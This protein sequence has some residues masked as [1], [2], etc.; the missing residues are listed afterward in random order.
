MLQVNVF[1]SMLTRLSKRK[2]TMLCIVIG[3][4]ISLGMYRC[5]L[6]YIP[7]DVTNNDVFLQGLPKILDGL[8]IVQLSDIHLGPY[9][10]E[11]LVNRAVDIANRCNPDIAVLTGD[12]TS[13]SSDYVDKCMEIMAKLKPKHGIFLV[14]GN[15]DYLLGIQA[16]R[17]AV[18]KHG[19]EL[20]MNSSREVVPGLYMVGI[21]DETEGHPDADRAFKGVPT[22]SAA[23]VITHEPSTIRF[24]KDRDM[25]VL[26]GHTHGGQIGIP[27]ITREF[28]TRSYGYRAGWYRIGKKQLYVNRGIGFS[29]RVAFRFRCNP[30]VSVFILHPAKD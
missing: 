30:E 7:I 18:S 26:T 11:D 2:K 22:D 23:V 4:L 6:H 17:E 1:I 3:L 9:V 21:D 5:W 15:H 10:P 28:I 25:L 24:I 27:F 8:R 14:P 19:L 16:F 13:I 12:Y 29:G 20:I